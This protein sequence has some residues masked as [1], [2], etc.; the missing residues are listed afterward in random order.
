VPIKRYTTTE[1]AVMLSAVLSIE[2]K[3]AKVARFARELQLGEMSGRR[4]LLSKREINAIQKRLRCGQQTS[5][6]TRRTRVY[7]NSARAKQ[8]GREEQETFDLIAQNPHNQQPRQQLAEFLAARDHTRA[9]HVRLLHE[10]TSELQVKKRADKE[11]RLRE[12]AEVFQKP[13]TAVFTNLLGMKFLL[14]PPG[15]FLMGSPVSDRKARDD[16]KQ[17]PVVLTKGFW[18]GETQVTQAVYTAVTK[19]KFYEGSYDRAGPN[20]PIS[21]VYWT[22]AEAFCRK[23]NTLERAEGNLPPGWKYTLPTEAQWEYACRAGTTTRFSFGKT[24]KRGDEFAW[25]Y[26]NCKGAEH[27]PHRVGMKKPNPWG[28]YD[29]HGNVHEWCLD[30]YRETLPGG[31]DP[32]IEEGMVNEG[33]GRVKRG[34]CFSGNLDKIARSA[35]RSKEGIYINRRFYWQ[36]F[37]VALASTRK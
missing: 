10:L 36:G 8:P 1:A 2:V 17:T 24:S 27:Y 3:R 34:G 6:S 37:R 14:I 22:D 25:S 19:E 21:S 4:R 29:M 35:A 18:L 15:Q 7:A 31:E 13:V 26:A 5:K 11:Q 16:E 20:Y 33:N 30:Y 28:L 32:L 23:L 12:L 9:E